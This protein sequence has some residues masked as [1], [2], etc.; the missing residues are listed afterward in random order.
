MMKKILVIED[1]DF[2]RENIVELL[3][4]EGFE[5]I[6]AENGHEGVDLAK[7][8]APD[9][10]L[11]DVMMPG[12]DG[13]GVLTA[14]RQESVTA[15]VPFIFLTAKAAKAD[16][17]QGMELGADDY[18]T[19][20][21][22]RAELLGAITSRLKKQAAVQQRYHTELQQAKQ[23]LDYL[24]YNDS[25][26]NLPNRLSLRER[27]KQVQSVD[28]SNEQLITVLSVALDRFN[29]INNNLGQPVGDLLIKAVADRLT[30]CVD[31]QDIVA[32][33]DAAQFAI[34][35]A[36]PQPKKEAGNIAQTILESLSQTFTLAGHE[37]FITASIGIAL[38]PRDGAEIEQ[39]L[40]HANTA[41]AKAKQQG[42]DQY[43]FYTPA[44]NI[45]S[46]D[47]LALQSS[48]RHALERQELQV[49]Y[50]PQLDLTTG[51]IVGAEALVRWQ[52][53]ERG[54]VSPDKFIPLAEETG[55]IIPIGEWVLQTACKQTQV[56][57][58]AGF[59]SLRV[60]VNLSS[61][62]FSQIDLRKQLVQILM[63]TG[64]DPKY[65]EL[66]L[67]ESMLV[68]NTEVAIRRLNALKS[69]GVQIA[70]DDFGTGYSSLSYLQQFPFDILKI[71]RC[72]IR[73]ITENANN[74]AITK[75]IIEMAKS[76]K[77]KL[78][79]EGVE[80]EA[81]LS[82]VYTHQCDGMQGYLFSRPVPAPE[83]EQL[84]RADKR[85]LLPVA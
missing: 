26:T 65:I 50:Q 7:A 38:Y 2:V 51:Q 15:A 30:A 47:R 70:I 33:L 66:E 43:E 24:S 16:F 73:N 74:A 59:S 1:E 60:A 9:L 14:L 8:M 18:I 45:G 29:Q 67:T 58:N 39:L 3:D 64:L 62:Q 77:L 72:F 44:F 22:T 13:Y 53:P 54:L 6:S 34:I 36:K 37:I 63:D 49:Y 42:G 81:E 19:K 52:H 21:F 4:V 40:N 78:I 55:L 17:R 20:P 75:A 79:A 85:L 57:Q 69:L 23:Q 10:I 5:V 27:F 82:F 84:L 11:C 68:Q 48:L 31:S 41:L 80:T 46:S 32:R 71:D 61:R 12:L 76:L 25:L 83:F 56:W 28:T 35:L